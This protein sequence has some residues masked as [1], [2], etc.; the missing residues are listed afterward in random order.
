LSKH[1]IIEALRAPRA[2]LSKSLENAAWASYLAAVHRRDH[3][4]RVLKSDPRAEQLLNPASVRQK[5]DASPGTTGTAGFG[6]ELAQTAVGGFF[7]SIQPLS[8][9]ARLIAM[10]ERVPLGATASVSF[11]IADSS[12]SATP[13]VEEGTP[14]GVRRFSFDADVL[15][16]AK[17]IATIVAFSRE[18]WKRG[19]AGRTIFNRL[20]GEVTAHSLDLAVFGDQ[21]ASDATCAGLRAGLTPV[22]GSGDPETDI[23]LLANAVSTLGGGGD[24]AFIANPQ[25]ANVLRIRLPALSLPVLASRAMP[26]GS[27]LAIDPTCFAISI[28]DLEIFA[29]E[30]SVIHVSDTPLEIVSATGPTTADPTRS[31]YQTGVVALRMIVDLSFVARGNRVALMESVSWI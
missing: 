5:A 7:T 24:V 13:W 15:G 23:I 19:A 11:P 1:N 9:A 25:E 29:A 12:P 31:T 22:G 18:L 2:D 16:P 27:I 21:A 26:T 8:A 30:E 17:K 28:S 4:A 14:I 3:A 20:L 10:G 6:A